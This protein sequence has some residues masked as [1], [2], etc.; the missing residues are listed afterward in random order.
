MKL[1]KILFLMCV[2]FQ[3]LAGMGCLVGLGFGL[4]ADKWMP[5][6][7]TSPLIIGYAIG[8]ILISRLVWQIE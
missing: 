5:Y 3:V 1:N 6:I 4:D 2:G 8:F 7:F